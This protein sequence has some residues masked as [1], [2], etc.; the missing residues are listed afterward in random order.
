LG[1]FPTRNT[2]VRQRPI[3]IR[4][5]LWRLLAF[6][7][8]GVGVFLGQTEQFGLNYFLGADFVDWCPVVLRTSRIEVRGFLPSLSGDLRVDDPLARFLD[9]PGPQRRGTRGPSTG[10]NPS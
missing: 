6:W 8:E 7:N 4:K 3:I 9:L 1:R 10:S 2:I 5:F